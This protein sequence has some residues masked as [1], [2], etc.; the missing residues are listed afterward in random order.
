MLDF[1]VTTEH[2]SIEEVFAKKFDE[3]TKYPMDNETADIFI[4]LTLSKD[5]PF[6][7]P[8]KQKPFI[9]KIIEHRIDLMHTY[10]VDNRVLLFLAY[11]CKT[12]GVGVMYCWYLQYKSKNM[13][14]KELTFEDF[15]EIFAWGFPSDDGLNKLWVAQKVERTDFDFSDNLLDYPKA[16]T[17][18]Y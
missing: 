10:K 2:T 12:A 14:K 3:L 7:I 15:T 11:I 16:G 5:I 1:N 13:N 6:E 4:K 18:L 9:Y 17:S 8:D